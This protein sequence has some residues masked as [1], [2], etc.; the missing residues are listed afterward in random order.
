MAL[1]AAYSLKPRSLSFENEYSLKDYNAFVKKHGG[2]DPKKKKVKP[3][4]W[5]NVAGVDLWHYLDSLT[6]A[7]EAGLVDDEKWPAQLFAT[8]DDLA[9]FIEVLSTYDEFWRIT[10]RWYQALGL[11]GDF[12]DTGEGIINCDA[13][14][15]EIWRHAIEDLGAFKEAA[16]PKAATKKVAAKKAPV[17]A[18]AKKKAKAKA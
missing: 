3:M 5:S 17:K 4:T 11:L 6:G 12:D 8:K 1:I 10:D 9:G 15:D 7:I 16:T 18:A 2:F 14:T 13:I